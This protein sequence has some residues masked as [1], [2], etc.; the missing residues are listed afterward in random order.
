MSSLT[1]RDTNTR[2][3]LVAVG[4][5]LLLLSS[6]HPHDRLTWWMETAPVWIALPLL[7]ATHRHFP[8]TPLACWLIFLHAVVLMVGGHYTYARVPLGQWVQEWFDLSR[9]HYDRL[10]HLMQGFAPAIVVR[11]IL[12]RRSP[13]HTGKWLFFLTTSVCLAISALYELIEWAAAITL[14]QGADEF[15][16]TQG[17]IWDTQ[18]DMFCALV[19]ALLAQAL[20]TRWH[21][22]QLLR[23]AATA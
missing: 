9:N 6:I 20:L 18:T 23:L 3:A 11:E 12:L 8:L 17:D 15:L 16:A 2:I 21:D 1:A 7:L 19:G 4:V 13:L 10:G 14:S 5:L 22:R